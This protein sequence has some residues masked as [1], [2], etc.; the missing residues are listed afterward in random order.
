MAKSTTRSEPEIDSHLR[1]TEGKPS[2]SRFDADF[3]CLG[4]RGLEVQLPPEPD[5]KNT[6]RGTKIHSGLEQ[7]D[8]SELSNSD[9]ITA[10]RCLYGVSEIIHKHGFEGAEV[11][12]EKRIWIVD[13]NLEPSWSAKLDDLY[14]LGDRA[15]VIDYKTGFG[16]TQPIAHN[17][18]IAAQCV[19]VRQERGQE[20]K[21]I[22]GALVHPHHPDSLF[23]E[24]SFT[25]D[26][27]DLNAVIINGKIAEIAKPDQPRTPNAVSCQYC[28]AKGICPEYR[29]KME[30]LAKDIVDEVKDE[31][32]TKLI[33]RSPEERGR[34]LKAIKMLEKSIET[35]VAQYVELAKKGD[36]VAGFALVKSWNKEITDES[37]AISTARK[38]WGDAAISAALKF[39]L[40]ALEKWL[41][42]QP[43]KTKKGAK[44][45]VE[46]ILKPLIK[47]K[48]KAQFLK[49]T[50]V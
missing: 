43:N 48:P 26:K 36:E 35:I 9:Q 3:R 46:A 31:G 11:E 21:S 15:L 37:S 50:V 32:F 29:A 40:V 45:E 7:S 44:E 16:V 39:N 5:N 42:E 14:I 22:V 6:K 8:F 18:Q 41:G 17:W 10:S 28:R 1:E 13:D 49:E 2:A 20:I 27:L 4:K 25:A 30:K 19:A 47:F 24:V 12:H 38:T 34:H 23:E 33:Q